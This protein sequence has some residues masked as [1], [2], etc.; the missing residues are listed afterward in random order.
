[1]CST[2]FEKKC[3]SIK[4]YKRGKVQ[5]GSPVKNFEPNVY[6]T[7]KVSIF[8]KLLLLVESYFK[9]GSA[10]SY[11]RTNGEKYLDLNHRVRIFIYV[12]KFCYLKMKDSISLSNH[13]LFHKSIIRGRIC[14]TIKTNIAKNCANIQ[15][16]KEGICFNT[17]TLIMLKY[18]L[19]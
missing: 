9:Y 8:L 13:K 16:K 17:A 12:I 4:K 19:L 3:I 15:I 18:T 11:N 1:M 5:L 2:L 6:K 10:F 14:I 7:P